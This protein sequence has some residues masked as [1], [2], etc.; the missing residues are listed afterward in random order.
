MLN[1][2]APHPSPLPRERE[3]VF[4]SRRGTLEPR[5]L[6]HHDRAADD[7]VFPVKIEQSVGDEFIGHGL[8]VI[9]PERQQNLVAPE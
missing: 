3:L 5:W 7:P 9:E 2:V 8:A 6:K 4:W 1:G